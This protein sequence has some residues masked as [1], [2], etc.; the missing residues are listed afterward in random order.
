M[1]IYPN[2]LN[3]KKGIYLKMGE[4]GGNLSKFGGTNANRLGELPHA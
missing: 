1:V 4:L 2:D 3:Y